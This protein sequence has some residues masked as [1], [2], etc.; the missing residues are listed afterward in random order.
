MIKSKIIYF[1]LIVIAIWYSILYNSYTSG[2]TLLVVLLLP[3]M[4]TLLLTI[5]FKKTTVKITLDNKENLELVSP[6][7]VINKDQEVELLLWVE[8]KSI[9]PI[10]H[11]IVVLQWENGLTK[12][13]RKEKRTIYV[14]GRSKQQFGITIKGQY[15]GSIVVMLKSYRIYDY[16]RLT[17][18]KKTLKQSV[19]ISVLPELHEIPVGEGHQSNTYGIVSDFYSKVKSGDDPSEVFDIRDYKEGDKLQRI[20][21][22]LSSKRSEWVVKE[23]SEPIYITHLIMIEFFTKESLKSQNRVPLTAALIEVSMSISYSLL[24]HGII[25]YIGWYNPLNDTI[26]KKLVHN[27]ED[28]IMMMEILLDVPLYEEHKYLLNYFNGNQELEQFSYIYYISSNITEEVKKTLIEANQRAKKKMVH[29]VDEKEKVKN[30]ILPF[31]KEQEI[32]ESSEIL[33][34]QVTPRKLKEEITQIVL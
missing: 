12:S 14:D 9:F 29:V 25:H 4:L 11:M 2:I 6:T 15:C 30:N 23:F 31:D 22:K 10:T 20:H 28:L 18:R 8:N 34:H 13:V 3:I 5:T 26:E 21:W 24:L 17:S 33:Y 1:L 16:L 7:I 32:L 27:E 19:Y